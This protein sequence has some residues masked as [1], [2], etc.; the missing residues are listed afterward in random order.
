MV[1]G[2]KKPEPVKKE[3]NELPGKLVKEINQSLRRIMMSEDLE[4]LEVRLLV[5]SVKSFDSVSVFSP[6]KGT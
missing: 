5:D 1:F 4:P 2:Q 6:N 3:K